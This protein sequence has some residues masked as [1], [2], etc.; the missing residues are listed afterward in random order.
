MSKGH[1]HLRRGDHLPEISH[2]SCQ[3]LVSAKNP[4]Q[5]H[6]KPLEKR[7]FWG[8]VAGVLECFTLLYMVCLVGCVNW[9]CRFTNMSQ[10]E[11][12]VELHW[13]PELLLPA[14]ILSNN[15]WVVL[16]KERTAEVFSYFEVLGVGVAGQLISL[17]TSRPRHWA[18]RLCLPVA[19]R[20]PAVLPTAWPPHQSSHSTEPH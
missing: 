6:L 13:G 16:K 10:H 20:S 1:E 3:V 12:K 4:A 2:L 18:Y 9:V 7:R 14:C 19:G 17:P 11:P 5:K 8:V 15:F